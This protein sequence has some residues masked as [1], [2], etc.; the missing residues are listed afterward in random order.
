MRLEQ[1]I[2]VENYSSGARSLVI[3]PI[4]RPTSHGELTVWDSMD[5][6]RPT[7]SLPNDFPAFVGALTRHVPGSPDEINAS[8]GSKFWRRDIRISDKG[9]DLLGVLQLF[10]SL[11]EALA[12]LTNPFWIEI[13]QRLSPEEPANN[14]RRV[15]NLASGLRKSA[16]R[17]CAYDIACEPFATGPRS[18]APRPFHL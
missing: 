17:E 8:N 14:P 3:P 15:N 9:R 11:P 4:F 10:Q 18:P 16:D 6:P 13:I 7:L 5:W 1:W 2:S 12:F